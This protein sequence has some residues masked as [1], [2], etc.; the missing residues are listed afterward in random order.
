[1]RSQLSLPLAFLLVASFFWTCNK[2]HEFKRRTVNCSD[3]SLQKT[4]R[5]EYISQVPQASKYYP[6]WKS[7]FL[8][9]NNVTEVFFNQHIKVFYLDTTIYR[10]TTYLNVGIEYSSGWA[11][12]NL[13]GQIIIR[14]NSQQSP[15]YTANLPINM[16]LT[17]EQILGLSDFAG[18]QIGNSVIRVS[19]DVT[20]K[21]NYPAAKEKIRKKLNLNKLCGC[22]CGIN[23]KGHLT[24]NY[25]DYFFDNTTYCTSSEL[26]LITGEIDGRV[27][28]CVIN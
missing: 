16:D 7:L 26:D 15:F 6:V 12:V 11:A 24:L 28:E 14:I 27:S 8:A 9:Q 21:F 22:L 1:M 2:S 4:N 23:S 10:H 19:K 25:H 3:E 13:Y 20:L 5:T 17:K 18:N